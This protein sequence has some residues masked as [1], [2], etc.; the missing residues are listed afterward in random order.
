MNTPKL[1]FK[2]FEGE[3]EYT[4]VKKVVDFYN[5]Q[6]EP[7][8]GNLREK[9]EYPYYGATGIIDYVKDYIF[10]GEYLLLA[11]D[12]ANI[13]TRSAPV[14][15]KTK[16]KFWV[17]NHAHIMRPKPSND[18]NFVYQVLEKTNFIPY[19]SGTA[20]PKL[21]VESV[22]KIPLIIPKYK[23]Q[24]KIGSLFTLLIRKIDKQQEKIEK[25]KELKKSMMQKIFSQELRF[26][27]EDGEE[28]D[29]WEEYK[30][31]DIATIKGRLGWKGLKQ[32]EYIE[33]GAYLI[34]GKHIRKGQ[35]QWEKCDQIPDFRYRESMEIALK[36]NDIIF[37]KDG[38]LGNPA[39]IKE[40]AKEA[41]INSTM[42]LVRIN[43]QVLPDFFYQLL[44]GPKFKKLI[45]IKVSGSSIP[46]LFQAD[47][48][49]FT[50]FAPNSIMEQ[51]K[52]SIF[53]GKIDAIINLEYEKHELLKEQKKG[54]TQRMFV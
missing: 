13:I 2:E 33:D 27:D 36:E 51:E 31:G 3:W 45:H 32:E 46:H 15:Y 19:N 42:M 47:M 25:L 39:L 21:N 38:S 54:F 53:L 5:N 1:R 37:S 24:Q 22:K 17:N 48:K 20:Q 26:M 49:E 41:T 12:G 35:I 28:F 29:A 9:G 4:I 7:I 8:T 30:L 23:E 44:L 14:V 18:L 10:D 34:A 52:I 40:L 11:E 43:E 50:F 6:R 16:N